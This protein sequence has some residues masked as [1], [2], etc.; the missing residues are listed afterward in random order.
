[1]NTIESIAEAIND[2]IQREMEFC[3]EDGINTTYTEQ[4]EHVL[5]E[6]KETATFLHYP[7]YT[8]K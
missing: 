3:K 2:I 7:N 4:L 1:M 5:S 8:N 6:L